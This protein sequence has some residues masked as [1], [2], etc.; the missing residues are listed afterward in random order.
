MCAATTSYM[1]Q[2]ATC[3][4]GFQSYLCSPEG[5]YL[6]TTARLTHF[7]CGKTQRSGKCAE[8]Y[9]WAL[10]LGDK[11]FYKSESGFFVWNFLSNVRTME[12]SVFK[13]RENQRATGIG[14]KMLD[15]PF[16]LSIYIYFVC[17]IRPFH[18]GHI[19]IHQPFNLVHEAELSIYEN[20]PGG[21]LSSIVPFG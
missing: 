1:S 19:F 15:W 12:R 5:M 9:V 3:C 20:H 2:M 8:D 10:P 13:R 7:D 21:T 14:R 11:V 4:D 6:L 18:L 17:P 16:I